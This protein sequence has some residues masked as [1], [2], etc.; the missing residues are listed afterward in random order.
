MYCV[1][2]RLIGWALAQLT[3][4]KRLKVINRSC[5]QVPLERKWRALSNYP[6]EKKNK[7]LKI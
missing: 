2:R 7:D 5:F 3:P 1:G 4:G 6:Y